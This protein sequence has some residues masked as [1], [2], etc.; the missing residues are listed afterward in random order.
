M[1][2]SRWVGGGIAAC[3]VAVSLINA[4]WIAPTPRDHLTLIAHH[5]LAQPS[6]G[7]SAAGCTAPRIRPVED[8]KYI[9]NSLPSMFKASRMG[10]AV[11]LDVQATAD[12]Q[13]IA[14]GDPVLECRT[15]GSGPVRARSLAELKT[16]DIGYGY[17]ADGGRTFPLRGRGIGGMPS[18]EEVLREVPQ[19]KLVFRFA[20]NDPRDADRLA[21]AFRRMGM[22]IDGKYAFHGARAVLERMRQLAPG[23]WTFDSGSD[24]ACLDDYLKVGWTGYVPASCRNTTIFIPIEGQWKIWGW[25]NRFQKRMADANSRLIMIGG[26]E[27]GRI[28]GIDHAEQ[29][30]D[31]PRDFRGWLWVEDFYEAGRALGR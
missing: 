13:M 2:V 18:A 19:A 29:L 7:D 8:N 24:G 30:G 23:A 10:A 6:D 15:N 25:P 20:G 3:A 17:T 9:E 16:L 11:E 5:G 14:F 12:G 21:A 31:V 26:R 27:H 22:P 28:V 4:S 1:R